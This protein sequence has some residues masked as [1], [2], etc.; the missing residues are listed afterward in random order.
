MT[1]SKIWKI[2]RHEYIINVRRL[3]FIFVTLLF[4]ALGLLA[5]IITAFFSGQ[6][7]SL[8]ARQFVDTQAPR[9]GVVDQSGLYNPIP[10]GFQ[11]Q[12]IPFPN[13]S[14]A[15]QA[16]LSGQVRSVLIVPTDYVQTGKV[17]AYIEQSGF[18]SNATAVDSNSLRSFLVSGL[19][20][21]KLDPTLVTRASQPANVNPVTLDAKGDPSTGGAFSFVSGFIAPYIFSILLFVSVFASSGYLLRGIS[22]EKETRVIE[23][24]LSSVSPTELL[25]GKVIGLGALGLTQIGVWLLSGALLSGGLAALVAGAVLI[26]NPTS[27]LLAALYF[28]LGYVLYGT[29]M[30]AAGALGTSMRESQQL[31]GIFSFMAAIPWF[32][33]GLVFTNPNATLLRVLC[34]F[35]FTAPTMMMLRLPLTQVPAVDII[36]ST[37]VLLISIPIVLWVG[38]RIFRMGLLMY[39]K[40]PSLREI[41]R[42]VRA[43]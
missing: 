18:M 1:I 32:F 9:I 12:F 36:G 39:G 37:I 30:A 33:A 2:A 15:K 22:E 26:L 7:A 14:M 20:Q 17:T 23:V 19:L 24:V 10:S 35:P 41:W 34:F 21:G 43:A 29:T 27:F 38:A 28:L 6:A 31:A 25:A 3:G 11:D 5:L 4:P 42:S 16:L 8:L 13:E 40:R